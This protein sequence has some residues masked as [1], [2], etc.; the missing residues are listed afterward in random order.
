MRAFWEYPLLAIIM[1]ITFRR[2]GV[3]SNRMSLFYEQAFN[4][5]F[6]EVDAA[7][8]VYTRDKREKISIQDFVKIFGAFCT[9]T[10]ISYR[11]NFGYHELSEEI[12]RASQ[13]T[14]VNVSVPGL[15]DDLIESVCL[16]QKDGLEYSFVHRSFQEYFAAVFLSRFTGDNVFRI[17]SHV[18]AKTRDSML[19]P[20]LREIDE[21]ALE[22]K[23]VFPIVQQ[24]WKVLG[25][26]SPRTDFVKFAG[27]FGNRVHVEC[28]PPFVASLR[29]TGNVAL[30][31]QIEAIGRLYGLTSAADV[32]STLAHVSLL[33]ET[34]SRLTEDEEM[35]ALRERLRKAAESDQKSKD[36]SID[37]AINVVDPLPPDSPFRDALLTIKDD[38]GKI[39]LGLYQR[40]SERQKMAAYLF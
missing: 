24:I 40:I 13:I 22:D 21:E 11:F 39:R 25:P 37:V 30:V 19:L 6:I 5:L 20:L 10:L 16:M 26:L 9:R 29:G 23:W 7:K 8:G 35:K 18:L 3:I 27:I 34:A 38:I 31:S 4:A 33:A 2:Y 28:K 12:E 36:G 15:I 1:L 32:R 17:Y 14:G